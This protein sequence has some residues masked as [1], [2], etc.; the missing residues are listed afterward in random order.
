MIILISPT[1]QMDFTS[2]LPESQNPA[3]SL[4]PRFL[5][6]AQT[7]NALL[8]GYDREA[9]ASLM[10]ISPALTDR[11]F[12]EIRAF[13]EPGAGRRPALYAYSGTVFQALGA[14][15]LRAG[16]LEYARRHL[17]I[18]SGLYGCLGPLDGV[19]S[20]RLEMKTALPNPEGANL[21]H[22]W[23]S[24]IARTLAADEALS[25]PAAPVLNLASG[26]YMRAVDRKVLNRRMITFHFKERAGEGLRT[27]G[28]YAKTA[29]G[30]MVRRILEE[31]VS[32]PRALQAGDTGGY[33]YDPAC[34]SENDWVFVR[35]TQ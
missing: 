21:S 30:R 17:R 24:R 16:D 7:L 11:T 25:D 18:L 3:D 35:D 1:K 12:R 19:E 26:E 23:K 32:D 22:F 31:R 8:R 33:R 4:R 27:V 28:M 14:D 9:L 20:Y 34:S 6:E 15:S 5:Q 10:K 2:P 29:R 13:G